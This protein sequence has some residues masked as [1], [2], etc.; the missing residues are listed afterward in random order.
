MQGHHVHHFVNI[1][2]EG[3]LLG[4]LALCCR[5]DLQLKS[6]SKEPIFPELRLTKLKENKDGW[7]DEEQRAAALRPKGPPQRQV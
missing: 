5:L 4:E 1:N 2:N 7:N 6:N 3:E